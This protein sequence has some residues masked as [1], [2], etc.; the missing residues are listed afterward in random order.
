MKIDGVSLHMQAAVKQIS[1]QTHIQLTYLGHQN[2]IACGTVS[3]G[4]TTVADALGLIVRCQYDM[5][6]GRDF[7]KTLRCL[8]IVTIF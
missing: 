6:C 8:N 1:A 4:F 3:T 7:M 2:T 5:R